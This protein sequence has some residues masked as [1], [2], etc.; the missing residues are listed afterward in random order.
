MYQELHM[1]ILEPVGIVLVILGILGLLYCGIA[2]MQRI[3]SEKS[4]RMKAV[5]MAKRKRTAYR[6]DREPWLF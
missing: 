1:S 6:S 2:Y 3:N 5:S 4:E